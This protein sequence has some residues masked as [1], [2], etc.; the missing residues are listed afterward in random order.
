MEENAI[1]QPEENGART[2]T[3]EE[4]NKI[5]SERL[6]RER[7]KS[8]PTPEETKLQ[9]LAAR[10]SRLTCREYV[11]EKNLN[12]ELLNIF[13]TDNAD[14]FKTNVEKLLELCPELDENHKKTVPRIVLGGGYHPVLRDSDPIADIFRK[15]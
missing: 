12:R 1:T 4:V 14:S 2:F 8:E 15:K 3:Q 10:E 13:S 7:S 5:V 6:A 11:T 9:E